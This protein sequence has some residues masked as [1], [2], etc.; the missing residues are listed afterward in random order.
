[1]TKWQLPT[2]T[3]FAPSTGN[4]CEVCRIFLQEEEEF[5]QASD[6]QFFEVA[7]GTEPVGEGTPLDDRQP[8]RLSLP[9]GGAVRVKG[10]VDRVD[11]VGEHRYAVWDYKISSG[12]GFDA[13]DPFVGGRR[14]QSVLYLRMIERALRA[15]L[16]QDAVVESFGY[17]FP[18][19]RTLGQR[20]SWTNAD[21]QAGNTIVQ[22]LCALIAAGSYLATDEADDCRFCDY[23]QICRDPR[24]VAECSQQLLASTELE[25][26]C[27]F[28]E[29]RHES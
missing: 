16:T 24:G 9:S 10:Q 21:L 3:P 28:R 23:V 11:R 17:F 12:H 27:G 5:C 1:M 14:V 18:S 7:L 22:R 8:A 4:W 2:K 25:S 15:Q 29:V 19:T 6:P 26:L 20:L 13:R